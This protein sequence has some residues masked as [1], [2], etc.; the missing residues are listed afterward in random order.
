MDGFNKVHVAPMV[1]VTTAH[2]NYFLRII[3]KNIGLY[4]EMVSTN[5]IRHGKVLNRVPRVEDKLT[6]QLAGNCPGEL[7]FCAGLAEYK[8]YAAIN[9]NVGCPSSKIKKANYGAVL[10]KS[11]SLVAACVGAMKDNC[12]IPVS[13]KTRIG[14]DDFDN[15][16]YLA[17]F[18]EQL[19]RSGCDEIVLHAR[20]ALLKGLSPKANRTIPRLRYDVVESIKKDF[21]DAKI[22]INGGIGAIGSIVNFC[23]SFD[24]VMLGR[25]IDKNP[26]I[27]Q[28]ID[29]CIYNDVTNNY[30]RHDIFQHYSS[31]IDMHKY[32]Y[33]NIMLMKPLMGLF[34]GTPLAKKW[35]KAIIDSFNSKNGIDLDGLRNLAF[36]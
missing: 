17:R 34:Y 9:L 19:L 12:D 32:S 2:F 3:S 18:I 8:G 10:F 20:K 24:S 14:V 29:K 21:P 5:S 16:Q 22:C 33:S 11:P 26:M 31:Y 23:D 6:I 4:T 15:Y 1:G 7:G 13:V 35:H 28:E 36:V 25:I 27:L 30:T